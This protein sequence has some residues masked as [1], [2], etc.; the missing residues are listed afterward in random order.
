MIT[1]TPRSSQSRKLRIQHWLLDQRIGKRHEE[2][3]EFE[4]LEEARDV[5]MRLTSGADRP[6]Q[7]GRLQ[8]HQR[9]H[10]A[11]GVELI[12]MGRYKR[13]AAEVGEVEV[14]DHQQVDAVHSEPLQAVLIAAH[15]PVVGI[16][17]PVLEPVP[18]GQLRSLAANAATSSGA[19]STRPT[20]VET[21]ASPG[22]RR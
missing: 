1:P 22:G 11:A 16:V 8:L 17:M 18:L 14:V 7:S 12:E 20:L 3:I 9:P 6:D 4:L 10:A 2:E 15:D 13:L 5:L 19:N 21:I